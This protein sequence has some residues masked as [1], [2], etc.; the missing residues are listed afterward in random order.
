MTWWIIFGYAIWIF[1]SIM[2][3][4]IM[5]AQLSVPFLSALLFAACLDKSY[6]EHFH[7][8]VGRKPS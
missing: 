1:F 4:I 7:P 3:F 6:S 2:Y 8:G 5:Y